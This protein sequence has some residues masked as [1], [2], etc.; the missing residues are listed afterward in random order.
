MLTTQV[1][2]VTA[3]L[4]DMLDDLAVDGEWPSV[5]LAV[6]SAN[7][8][9][10]HDVGG[11]N[12]PDNGL[13]LA[14]PNCLVDGRYLIDE[15]GADGQRQINYQ[16]TF[17]E[18]A[19]CLGSLGVAGCGFEQHFEGMKR[20]LDGSHPEQADFRREGALLVVLFLADEDDCS[21]SD[22]GL[23]DPTD[24][25]L[26]A[27][28][29]FRCIAHSLDCAGAATP[30]AGESATY[31]QCQPR[32]DSPYFHAPSHYADFL[33]SLQPAPADIFVGGVLGEP[34][35][36]DVDAVDPG[37]P[38]ASGSCSEFPPVG[39]VAPAFRL[40][41]FLDEFPARS[42]ALPICAPSLADQ[43]SGMTQAITTAWQ[44][45]GC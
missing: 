31:D 14:A 30:L 10:G 38:V 5:H 23:F 29:S 37:R 16:G 24:E 19:R 33:A 1:D 17:A 7:V 27:F 13:M 21:A 28:G 8:D 26:G 34:G 3:W 42:M 9:I 35:S 40:H 2:V 36:M 6:T 18:A 20:A 45:P 39:P 32:M 12:E 25:Q 44:N 41:A 22:V 43:L 11:C 15:P 4:D